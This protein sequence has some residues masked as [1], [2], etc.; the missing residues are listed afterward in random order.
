[1]TEK[2]VELLM[3]QPPTTVVD[4]VMTKEGVKAGSEILRK[5]RDEGLEKAVS[6]M[7]LIHKW[8][9]DRYLIARSEQDLDKQGS[10]PLSRGRWF[11]IP[12]CCVKAYT[13]HEKEELGKRLSLQELRMLERGESVPDEFYLGSMGYIPCSMTCKPTLDRGLRT[14]AALDRIDP[15]LWSK[16]RDFHIRR[17]LAEYGGEI[18]LWRRAEK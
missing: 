13:E 7:G 4:L 16:F 18:K 9:G 1:M 12:E 14:R 3:R 5:Q 10:D 6:A 2:F 17:R 15:R 8:V 11:G